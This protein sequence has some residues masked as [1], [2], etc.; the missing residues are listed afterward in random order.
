MEAIRQIQTVENGEV[1]LRLP[2]RFWGR[3]VE[4]IVLPAPPPAT[5]APTDKKSLRGC[6]KPYAKPELIAKE[7]KAWQTAV[8]EKYGDR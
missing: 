3:E 6:L 7:E 2:K 1:H 8:S 4:I 5:Q